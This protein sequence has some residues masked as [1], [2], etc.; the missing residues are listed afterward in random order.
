MERKHLPKYLYEVF[1][2]E[3]NLLKKENNL[4][5]EDI[6]GVHVQKLFYL[7]VKLLVRVGH[8]SGRHGCSHITATCREERTKGNLQ[9]L[10]TSQITAQK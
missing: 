3:C 2:W 6:V 1:P 9:L 8:T 7:F 4:Y 10:L 5:Q